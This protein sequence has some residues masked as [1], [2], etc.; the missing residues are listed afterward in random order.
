MSPPVPFGVRAL[1]LSHA[2]AWPT[3]AWTGAA[4]AFAAGLDL[5]PPQW[6]LLAALVVV[7]GSAVRMTTGQL[8]G[9]WLALHADVRDGLRAPSAPAPTDYDAV[10]LGALRA[11]APPAR[12]PSP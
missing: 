11:L 3:A 5:A 8:V 7:C 12:P 4:T 2:R 1:A 6:A 10:T 9:A